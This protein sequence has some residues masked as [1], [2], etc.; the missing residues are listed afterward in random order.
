[1]NFDQKKRLINSTSNER[2]LWSWTWRSTLLC[3][4]IAICPPVCIAD[5]IP[6]SFRMVSKHRSTNRRKYECRCWGTWS[7]DED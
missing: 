2:I 6:P 4:K 1:M 7:S 3:Q 5:G